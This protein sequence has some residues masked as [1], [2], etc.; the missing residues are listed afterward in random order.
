MRQSSTVS[1]S[2]VSGKIYGACFTPPRRTSFSLVSKILMEIQAINISLQLLLLSELS[3]SSRPGHHVKRST[4]EWLAK[5][6]WISSKIV[7]YVGIEVAS[8]SSF[9][10]PTPGM[11]RACIAL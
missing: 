9:S 2:S 8:T 4:P 5:E 7:F 3:S 10:F 1:L 6:K 11:S